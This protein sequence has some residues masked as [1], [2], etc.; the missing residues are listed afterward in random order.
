[1]SHDLNQVPFF[2]YK[3]FFSAERDRIL[4]LIDQ[5]A[6][7]GGFI[8]QT[9]LALFEKNLAGLCNANGAVG[10]GNA[11]DALEMALSVYNL[12]KGDE[13]IIS[14]HTMVATAS[15]VKFAGAI[16]IPVEITPEGLMDPDDAE[17]AITKNTVGIMPTQLNGRVCDMDR[18]LEIKEKYGLVLVEDAAQSLGARYK[19]RYSGTFGDSSCVSFYPAKTLGCLGDG[20]ALLV[21]NPDMLE[22]FQ[23]MRDHGR[24][25]SGEIEIWGRN[26]RLDNLQAAILNDKLSRYDQAISYRRSLAALY[27][28]RLFDLHELKLPPNPLKDTTVFDI[29]QNYEVL[30]E[31]RFELQQYLRERGIGTLVQWGGKAIHQLK[32][33]GFKQELPKTDDYF[34]KCLLLPLNTMVT[35]D[36]VNYVCD[37][38]IDFYRK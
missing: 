37:A 33:L 24:S 21:N 12:E 19:D 5:V 8:M 18:L 30:V 4:E 31:K 16:P 29:C 17:R 11:T 34:R 28:S 27:Y 38:I 13:I 10:V 14:S 7:T 35:K 3:T 1:M 23:M 6:S 9:D 15:A 26:S 2:D 20:G 32:K 25:K 36:D 22:T